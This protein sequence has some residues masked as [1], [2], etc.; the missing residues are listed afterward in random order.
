MKIGV[1]YPI[2]FAKEKKGIPSDEERIQT[3]YTYDFNRGDCRV[4]LRV[5]HRMRRR[6]QGDVNRPRAYA[7]APDI[8]ND[9]RRSTRDNNTAHDSPRSDN[10]AE[11]N[12]HR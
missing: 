5:R 10:G 4:N 6:K 1:Q 7:Q 8:G 12:D 11:N 9:D 2:L 3:N